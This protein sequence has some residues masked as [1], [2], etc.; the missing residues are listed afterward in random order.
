MTAEYELDQI[1]VTEGIHMTRRHGPLTAT[2]H[3]TWG[4]GNSSNIQI[5][6]REFSQSSRTRINP[7]RS[8]T[9]A[10]TRS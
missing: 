5:S 8:S 9:L 4:S 6:E 7:E 10:S 2:K 1:G 3:A